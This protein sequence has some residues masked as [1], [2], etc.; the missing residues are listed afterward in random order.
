MLSPDRHDLLLAHL[1]EHGSARISDL[2]GL[3]GVSDVTVRRD[4]EALEREGLVRRFHGGVVLDRRA[5][6]DGVP[7]RAPATLRLGLLLPNGLYF[8][9]V[10]QGAREAASELNAELTLAFSDHEPEQDLVAI[11]RHLDDGVDGLLLAPPTLENSRHTRFEE[12]LRELRIPVVLVERELRSTTLVDRL[13][14]VVTDHQ[15]GARLAVEHLA[16]LGHRRIALMVKDLGP[17]A[18]AVR[19]GHAQAL[20]ALGLDQDAPVRLVPQRE[21]SAHTEQRV[22]EVLD[23]LRAHG[24]T[25]VLAHGDAEAIVLLQLAAQRGV[26]VPQDLAI[27]SY[28]DEV[29]AL[30]SIPLTAVAPPKRALGREGVE[31]L[32]SRLRSPRPLPVHHLTLQPALA[33]RASCGSGPGGRGRGRRGC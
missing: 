14:H 17:T 1:R 10:L 15:A 8:R 22:D 25:A 18:P 27:V 4:V 28:D 7:E 24:A 6:T 19:L 23:D 31:L 13:D 16:R 3:L 11:R 33:V 32:V 5:V 20:R 30:A 2:V 21:T 9:E 26:R 29:A 12:R